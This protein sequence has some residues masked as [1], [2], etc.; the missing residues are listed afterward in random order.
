MYQEEYKRWMVISFIK[1]RRPDVIC[2]VDNCYGEFMF[3]LPFTAFSVT[4]F[5]FNHKTLYLY[6]ILIYIYQK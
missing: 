1:E 2:M 5:R 6:C 3:V 4:L